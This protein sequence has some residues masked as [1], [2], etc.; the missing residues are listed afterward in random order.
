[1]NEKIS[2]KVKLIILPNLFPKPKA[3]GIPIIIT[4][5]CA[6]TFANLE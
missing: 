1:M 3:K 4:I 5:M 6:K 2:A